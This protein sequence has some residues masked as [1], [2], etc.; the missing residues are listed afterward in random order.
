MYSCWSVNR[1]VAWA[2]ARF[3]E[4]EPKDRRNCGSVWNRG[5]NSHALHMD[6]I[7]TVCVWAR[8]KKDLVP[9]CLYLWVRLYDIICVPMLQVFGIDDSQTGETADLFGLSQH[10]FALSDLGL[11]QD[12]RRWICAKFMPRP[13][14][15]TGVDTA[16]EH[17]QKPH[18]STHQFAPFNLRYIISGSALLA[19]LAHNP[20]KLRPGAQQALP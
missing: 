5:C 14:E 19:S 9:W 7:V 11:L 15:V 4:A 20:A 2:R 12:G 17:L 6:V 16:P 1:L 8:Q 18:I 10:G 3:Y 13:M